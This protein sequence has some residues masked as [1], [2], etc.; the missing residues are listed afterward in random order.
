[1]VKKK[2]VHKKINNIRNEEKNTTSD[3][4]EIIKLNEHCII[5]RSQN[6]KISSKY[7]SPRLTQMDKLKRQEFVEEVF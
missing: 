3:N 6:R 1:M 4:E 7:K 5:K 2:T